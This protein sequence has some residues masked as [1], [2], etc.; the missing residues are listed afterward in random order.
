MSRYKE[1]TSKVGPVTI[2]LDNVS[3]VDRICSKTS[4]IV[5]A[6]SSVFVLDMS[7]DEAV[8]KF[9][10]MDKE[11]VDSEV[12]YN[13]GPVNVIKPPENKAIK[14]KVKNAKSNKNS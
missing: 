2:N 13:K 1:F 6:D 7:Y 8:R 9:C 14:R 3:Y 10:P 11:V 12:F 4:R 5:M